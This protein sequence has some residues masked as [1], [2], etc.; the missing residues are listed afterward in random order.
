MTAA[1]RVAGTIAVDVQ[2]RQAVAC[3]DMA[4]LFSA[5]FS[6]PS[7]ELAQALRAGA[8]AHDLCACLS[9]LG[10]SESCLHKVEVLGRGLSPQGLQSDTGSLLDELKRE[11]FRLFLAPGRLVA[12]YPYESAFRFVAQ[13]GEGPPALFVNPC[14]VDVEACLRRADALPADYRKEPVD[15]VFREL[16]FLRLL[17]THVAVSLNEAAGDGAD[18]GTDA[19]D[20]ADAG[21]NARL[22]AE[23]LQ[24]F[25]AAHVDSWMPRFF[26]RVKK[27]ARHEV[28]ARLAASAL[29]SLENMPDISQWSL[30]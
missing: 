20:G 12:V 17:Y 28:Y 18:A 15:A 26:E 30:P 4:E 25:R 9:E 22:W 8:V 13:G 2:Q 16:D 5:A 10:V 23:Q 6:F 1:E 11:Y 29:V 24:S 27:E 7:L 3:A 14:T 19:G 21:G